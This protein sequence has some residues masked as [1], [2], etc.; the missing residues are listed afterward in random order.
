MVVWATFGKVTTNVFIDTGVMVIGCHKLLNLDNHV[1]AEGFHVH[2][3]KL[4]GQEITK[5]VELGLMSVHGS[6]PFLFKKMEE[7]VNKGVVSVR[8]QVQ[9]SFKSG[10]H[11]A[12]EKHLSVVIVL[13][14]VCVEV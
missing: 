10:V 9:F 5:K 12:N 8:A 7:T 13:A 14:I 3:W 6:R 1:V 4:T 11:R 2:V